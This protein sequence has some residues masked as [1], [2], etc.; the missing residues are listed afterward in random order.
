M[1]SELSK[2]LVEELDNAFK[3]HP[4]T[5]NIKCDICGKTSDQNLVMAGVG[6]SLDLHPFYECACGMLTA[7]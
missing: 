2:E 4:R 1:D 5:K 3:L 6:D 7:T